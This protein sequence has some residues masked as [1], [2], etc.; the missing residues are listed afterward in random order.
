MY[1]KSGFTLIEIIIAIA[2]FGIIALTSFVYYSSVKK[3]SLIKTAVS[4]IILTIELAQ[5]KTLASLNLSSFGVK[6]DNGSYTLFEGS[7]YSSTSTDNTIYSLPAELEIVNIS[8]SGGGSEIVFDRITG[9]TSN[10]GTFQVRVKD[11]P[12]QIRTIV[13]NSSGKVNV[14]STSLPPS[15]T[16]KYDSRHVHFTYSQNVSLATTLTL[17]FVGFTQVNIPFQDYY[18]P[19]SGKFSWSGTIN[20]GGEDQTLKIITHKIDPAYA[21]FSVTR[22]LRYN[23]KAVSINLDGENLIN[24]SSTGTTT[25]GLSANVSD[26]VLQ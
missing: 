15:G 13:V 11:N 1:K 17:D 18:D 8:L 26:P 4:D 6:L 12:S 14:L 7:F 10:Y 2:V 5:N 19:A 21:D 16:R 23:T 9:K 3:N 22:D 20:V 24:Y 25:K